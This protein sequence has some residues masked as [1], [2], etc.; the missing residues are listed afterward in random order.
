MYSLFM[1]FPRNQFRKSFESKGL[2]FKSTKSPLSFSDSVMIICTYTYIGHD[3]LQRQD[4]TINKHDRYEKLQNII[5][6]ITTEKFSKKKKTTL[7]LHTSFSNKLHFF[8]QISVIPNI[9]L[10]VKIEGNMI[11]KTPCEFCGTTY[12]APKS[13]AIL[14]YEALYTFFKPLVFVPKR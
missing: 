2:S 4:I 1:T 6:F 8:F 13:S 5:H 10:Y 9:M 11:Q 3:E 12:F 14:I 7:Q